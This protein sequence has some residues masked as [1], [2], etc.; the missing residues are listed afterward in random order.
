[1]I[2]QIAIPVIAMAG[3]GL[4]FGVGIAYA[5][6]L[7]G[8]EVDPTVALIIT[9]LPGSNCGACGRAGCAG[10][11]EAL[12]KGDA[13]PSA[14]VLAND[15]ARED[16]AGILGIDYNPKVRTVATLLCNGGANAKDK[17]AYKGIKTCKA[18]SLIFGGYKVC[19]FGCLGSG[20]CVEACQFGALKMA[21][22]GI[23][24]VDPKKCTA[25][26][27]C[28]KACPKKLFTLTPV[29]GRYYVKCSSTDP[30]GVTARACAAGCI[31]CMKC[32]KA[33]PIGA[34]K[35]KSNL[36]R[37]H[38]EECQNMGKCFEVCP[39]KVI[40]RRG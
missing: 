5:L 4:V 33:C 6:K 38:Y 35:V 19:S 26:G 13:L 10:L 28:V 8:I 27:R 31:A 1:M 17:F 23:P 22:Q 32:E 2:T 36:S 21:A 3:L 9:K 39:T 34:V 7:F 12:K 14:C 11:A 24:E 30:G 40:F 18:A 29:T 37:I 25:C 16:I 15:K 20:D